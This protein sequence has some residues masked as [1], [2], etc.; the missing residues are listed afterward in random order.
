MS[1]LNDDLDGAHRALQSVYSQM[2]ALKQALAEAQKQ[3]Q[4][5]QG[6]V[7]PAVKGVGTAASP[8]SGAAA[9]ACMDAAVQVPEGMGTQAP[10]ASDDGPGSLG[11]VLANL[12]AVPPSHSAAMLQ[13]HLGTVLRHTGACYC[14]DGSKA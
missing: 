6:T 11:D 10:A 14:P 7:T 2:E 13:T 4:Q 5:T 9:V 8:A 3:R 12:L 1:V